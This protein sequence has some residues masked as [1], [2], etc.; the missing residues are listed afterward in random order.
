M[1]PSAVGERQMLPMHTKR[2]RI[3]TRMAR[4]VSERA[5]G[6]SMRTMNLLLFPP[7]LIKRALDDLSAI[8][9]VARRLPQLEAQVLGRADTLNVQLVGVRQEVERLRAEMLPIQE[10]PKVRE[11]IDPLDD[12]MRSVRDSVDNL[13]PLLARIDERL[14]GLRGDL[15][16]LGDLADK[17][18][19]M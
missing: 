3:A 19:G 12:D 5:A 16:P 2:I 18:P 1:T 8:A 4:P 17:I 13:E 10:L 6:G 9:Y 14:Q 15:A 11:G 7:T